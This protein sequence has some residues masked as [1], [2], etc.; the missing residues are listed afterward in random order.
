MRKLTLLAAVMLL[1][2]LALLGASPGRVGLED[3]VRGKH[4]GTHTYVFRSNTQ[5]GSD[6]GAYPAAPDSVVSLDQTDLRF[7]EVVLGDTNDSYTI[8]YT[9]ILAQQ[10]NHTTRKWPSTA[11]T[12]SHALMRVP[13]EDYIPDGSTILNAYL[14]V[15]WSG[16]S[17]TLDAGDTTWVALDTLSADR[18]WYTG[19]KTWSR[20]HDAAASWNWQIQGYNLAG[21]TDSTTLKNAGYPRWHQHAWDPPLSSRSLT[22]DFGPRSMGNVIARTLAAGD[23]L[24]LNCTRPVQLAVNGAPNHGF[25]ILH[26]NNNSGDD[27]NFIPAHFAATAGDHDGLVGVRR[28]FL[29]I[30]W[31]DKPY[32]GPW[33]NGKE[34]AF[35][36]TT[37]DGITAFN[38]ALAD[39]FH[40][41]GLSFTA[42]VNDSSVVYSAAAE[43][44]ADGAEVGY[45][46]RY[47]RAPNYLPQ[48]EDTPTGLKALYNEMDPSRLYA[49]IA[50]A[51][52]QTQAAVALN[53]L[54]GK[55]FALPGNLYNQRVVSMGGRFGYVALR[56]G[57][58][59]ESNNYS[60][61]PPDTT[62]RVPISDKR[63]QR[64]YNILLTS[65]YRTAGD[66]FGSVG[67]QN[68]AAAV[69]RTARLW[70]EELLTRY[71]GGPWVML[72]HDLWGQSNGAINWT[73]LTAL[74][75]YFHDAGNVW[76]TN[77]YSMRLLQRRYGTYIAHP[78]WGA[79]AWQDSISITDKMWW[80]SS[81]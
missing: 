65:Q 24:T 36:F 16:G 10:A 77:L 72:V 47:H 7:D 62:L 23:T 20:A 34:S 58:V 71:G 48:Y 3:V 4:T 76:V 40:G 80:K 21:I 11:S 73:Q 29:V 54:V 67:S 70:H 38:T 59:G 26:T 33:A 64:P 78:A 35:V 14:G 52:G 22:I 19:P 12:G 17:T 2:L 81:I 79:Q 53:P 63:S 66:L 28:T 25:W 15:I 32:A 5:T 13:F 61:A 42:F 1:P 50:T 60:P 68:S 30:Q 51:T 41:R 43:W 39:T 9:Y 37:D 57:V 49:G 46:G 31:S 45:H 27:T 74:L 44:L 55:T 6:H 69:K 75:D 18:W 56:T 8:S